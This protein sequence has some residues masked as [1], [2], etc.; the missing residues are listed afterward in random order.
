MAKQ[1]K[2][3]KPTKSKS[4]DK[5]STAK[6]EYQAPDGTAHA[7]RETIESI[8][9]AF[10][11]A[12]LFRT[13]EAE[14]FVI[15]T[16][17]MSPSLQ[18]RHKDVDC[19][20]CGYRFRVSASEEED[21]RAQ[22]LLAQIRGRRLNIG[23]RRELE[24]NLHSL[25]VVGG[26]CPMCRQIMPLQDNLPEGPDDQPLLSKDNHDSYPGDRILVNKY[27]YGFNEPERWDVVVFK[28]PGN[29]EM[30]YIKRL[31]G[32]SNEELR[33]YQGDLFT[34]P[35]GSNE[36]FQIER[37]PADKVAA[38]LQPVH[39][40]E[41]ESS[42]LFRA[43]WPTRW[44]AEQDS[45]WKIAAE[46]EKHTVQQSFSIDASA[47]AQ[48]QWL[49]YRHYVPT[50]S[51]WSVAR[52]ILEQGELST[53][54]QDRWKEGALPQL[55]LDFNSYNS[56]LNRGGA[57]QNFSGLN[58]PQGVLNVGWRFAQ[59][60]AADQFG[61]NWVGDL[62]VECEL[63]VKEKRGELLLDLVEGGK[64]F[65]CRIDLATGQ[66]S[67]SIEGLADYNPQAE[68]SMNGTGSYEV[69]FANVD[70]QL[71][72][73]ID[74]DLVDFED[75]AYDVE[76]VFG[77]RERIIP[78]STESQPGDLRPIGIGA[79][80]AALEISH[81][82]VMRDIYYIAVNQSDSPNVVFDYDPWFDPT[83]TPEDERIPSLRSHREL[84]TNP[85]A[86]PRFLTRQARVF[87]VGEDQFFVMGDNSP[88]SLDCRLWTQ[89]RNDGSHPGG[90]YLDRRLLTGKAVCVFWPHSWGSIPGLEWVP[91]FPNFGDMRIVR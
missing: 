86:W 27:G 41:Y 69:R 4:R 15:P 79:D 81:L 49:H 64:H 42:T 39:D 61:A 3:T 43:G 44:S 77:E 75:T 84:F 87:D 59:Q 18:G 85:D 14:A 68:T 2:K 7:M 38:M 6:A 78:R 24:A 10:V 33:V 20:E 19:G 62:A 76:R 51:D 36:P 73:W 71:L 72:L 80:G 83:R 26:V 57:N 65:G 25:D 32:L 53:I 50:E 90:S 22:E 82:R 89:Q 63:D 40:S 74:G 21:E 31:V 28:F 23:Q 55:V 58:L 70:D 16:G 1:S 9:I 5:T 91:G 45:Q 35:L 67:L 37:K 48:P 56:G 47:D 52:R 34:R 11:L 8:V 17:S 30:N 13:F 88:Q 46:P 29:G 12:F 54:D 60:N 66:A